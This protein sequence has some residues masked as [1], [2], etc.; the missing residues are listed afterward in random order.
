MI[1]GKMHFEGG[2]LYGMGEMIDSKIRDAQKQGVGAI[3]EWPAG[4]S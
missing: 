1:S 4:G 3:R 2:K